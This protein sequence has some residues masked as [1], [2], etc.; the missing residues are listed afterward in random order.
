MI[1]QLERFM[2]R[3]GNCIVQYA[4][5]RAAAK[6][7]G[8]TLETPDWIG[9]QVFD[10]VNDPSIG[11]RLTPLPPEVIPTKPGVAF[12]GYFQFQQAFDLMSRSELKQWLR[13]KPELMALCPKPRPFYIACHIRRG[14]YR[15]H[16]HL[17]AVVEKQC[18]LNGLA[19]FGY[20]ESDVIWLTEETPQPGSEMMPKGLE[21]LYDFML[22]LQAD[23]VF[24][25]NSTFSQWGAILSDS[26]KLYSPLVGDKVGTREDVEFVDGNHCAN[27][28]MRHHPGVPHS[29]MVLKD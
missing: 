7:L 21:F 16:P 23:V 3:W 4:V 11:R 9:R 22:L 15:D 27:L 13:I 17:F 20:S 10:G 14:D 19:K 24:R 5:A 25:S 1:V 28:S 2:G 8:A 18:F 6:R 26:Q 12:H 29:D